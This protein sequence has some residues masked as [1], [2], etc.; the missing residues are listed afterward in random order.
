M[1][2]GLALWLFIARKIFIREYAIT[3]LAIRGAI[4]AASGDLLVNH[5]KG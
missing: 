3:T 4:L 5:Q 2:L 1:V